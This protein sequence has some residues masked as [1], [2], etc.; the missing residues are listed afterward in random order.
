LPPGHPP[1]PAEIDI[2]PLLQHAKSNPKDFKAQ[3][4]AAEALYQSGRFEEAAEYYKKAH[5]LAPN[6]EMTYTVIVSLG[7]VYFDA[8]HAANDDTER[9]KQAEEWYRKALEINPKDTNVRTDLGITYFYRNPPEI[10]KAIA[11]YQKVLELNPQH[12]QALQNMTVAML[13]KGDIKGADEMITRLSAIAPGNPVVA[14]LRE[15]INRMK[16]GQ[17]LSQ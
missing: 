17:P 5:G 11:E 7:N 1:L 8:A 15:D 14:Q 13:K 9:Y 4:D 3:F 6:Q 2:A 16:S 10:D 12:P